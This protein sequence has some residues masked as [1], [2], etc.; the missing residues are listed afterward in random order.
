M[1]II[2]I[3]ILFSY[4]KGGIFIISKKNLNEVIVDS[5]IGKKKIDYKGSAISAVRLDAYKA[6]DGIPI[7][8]QKFIDYKDYAAWGEIVKKIDY[9]YYN[10]DCLLSKLDK[11]IHFKEKVK[12]DVNKGKKLLFKPNIIGSIAIDPITHREADT[13]KI[14]TEW[15]IV[16][17]IMRWFHDELNISYSKMSI[18]ESSASTLMISKFLSNIAGKEIT[19]QAVIE[20]KS[21]EFYGGWGFY[22]VRKY[23][24]ECNLYS[25]KD[26]PMNGYE[27]SIYGTY[28]SPGEAYNQLMVYNL[29]DI[30]IDDSKGRII[31]IDDGSNYEEIKMHKVIVGGDESDEDDIYKYP[32]CVLIN[33][34]RV[35]IHDQDLLS[36]AIK[37]LGM[38]I[39]PYSPWNMEIDEETKLPK[40]NEDG[41]YIKYKTYGISG[42]QSDIIKAIKSQDIFM[43]HILDAIEIMNKSHDSANA[44]PTKEGFIFS[45]LDCVAIDLFTSRYCFKN[46]PMAKAIKIKEENNWSTDFIQK[47]PIAEIEN[48]NIIT[49]YGYDS[50]L[51]RYDLY[52]YAQKRGIGNQLYYVVGIDNLTKKPL[53]SLNGHLGKIEE[54]TFVEV[55]TENFYYSLVT[56]MH[57]LQSTILSYLKSYDKL[58][59]TSIFNT[60]MD[61]YDENKDGVVDYNE[62]GRGFEDAIYNILEECYKSFNERYGQ[63][64]TNFLMVRSFIKNVRKDWNHQG[65][66]FIIDRVYVNIAQ[67]AYEMSQSEEVNDDL[68]IE[69]MKFGRGM[70]PSWK[71]AT[72]VLYMSYIYGSVTEE[73]ISIDSLYGWAFQYAD[74]V[75]N[76]GKYTKKI[77]E[78]IMSLESIQ[79]NIPKVSP[80]ILKSDKCINNSIKKYFE[81]IYNGEQ[82]LDFTLYVPFEFV[83][84]QGVKIPN[85]EGTDDKDKIF[86]VRFSENW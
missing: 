44:Q 55:I 17:A 11:E 83:Y 86:T 71:T 59:N 46:I 64:K 5:K 74:K 56:I 8:L 81:D 27:E 78:N 63:L 51:L 13:K 12:Y 20:G 3:A 41:D 10:I 19:P 61:I 39:H 75:L 57:S 42:T 54:N 2:K 43:I 49:T 1:N 6:Y 48:N 66:D 15:P 73:Y 16:A 82:P 21:E 40:M 58:A 18:G 65:H 32:G 38:G 70:W 84:I 29:N 14:C 25:H 22:F 33:I 47:V 85:I 7:L 77:K 45:S 35:K 52:N 4:K 26:N 60:I 62:K 67:V 68:F 37:N 50:P 53:V 30:G 72:Y 34:P 23:L 28:L 69:N 79:G 9:I 76:F 80:H 24:K 31:K 36:G